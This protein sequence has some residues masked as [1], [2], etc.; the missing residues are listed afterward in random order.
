MSK[1]NGLKRITLIGAMMVAMMAALP[2]GAQQYVFLYKDGNTY[3]FMQRTGTGTTS[4]GN[5]TTFNA[6]TCVWTGN[7]T[8]SSTYINGGY[9]LQRV[10]GNT[11]NL[12]AANDAST[13][14]ITTYGRTYYDA[15]TD[16]YIYYNNGWALT[17][18][19][20]PGTGAAYTVLYTY[21]TQEASLSTPVITGNDILTSATTYNYSVSATSVPAHSQFSGYNSTT[22]VTYY[23]Y[24][25]AMSTQS[26]SEN[27]TSGTWSLSDNAA[28]YATVNS[29]NGRITVSSLPE[30]DITIT[31]TCSVTSNGSTKTVT[32]EITIQGTKPSA[33]TITISGSSAT[34]TTDAP[35]T[36][37][38]RYTTNGND[39]TATTGT[40]YN[41]AIDLSSST[42]SPVTIK[43]VTV[44]NGNASDVTEQTV[45]LTLPAPTITANAD[46][47]TA[48]IS[49]SV[50][51][52][53]IYYTT[54]GSTPTTSSSQ[55]TGALSGL[56]LMTTVQAI[57]VKDGW[58]ASPVATELLT[59]SSNV[60]DGVVTLFDYEDHTW[61]YYSG[62]D[63][64]V[65]GG[66]Y[67]TN[68]L[69]KLY[70]PNPRNVKITYNGV[71]GITGSTTA[72]K[73]SVNSGETQ[74]Q[75]VYYKTLEE[76]STSGEY[77]YQVIS[78]PFSVR[79][80]TGTGNSK[81]YYGFAGWK[82]VSG[83]EYI[84]NHNNNDV[85]ALDEEIV[86]NNLP[87]P[88]V[89]CTSAEIV[90]QTTWTQ[91]NVRTGNNI[92]TMLGNF[93]GGT[94]ETNFAVLTGNYTTAWTGNKNATITSVMPDGSADNRGAYTRLNVT[95][96][97]G[98]TI[99]YEYI[100]IN[101]SS[102]TLSMGT[103]TKTLYIG[104]GVSNTTANGVV[105][106]TI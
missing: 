50:A 22:A 27:V 41:G 20:N 91:A 100:N 43:A 86:F 95:V 60:T 25:G 2:A 84:K 106:A 92:A 11:L 58:N 12:V 35:G 23:Y 93:S 54:D 18:S 3:N 98:Y 71:N 33:P 81:V 88:S 44:R 31:L 48:T 7:G 68:Y 62:V 5:T 34:I 49:S 21:T 51:G 53:T 78:N 56:A 72:V 96:N 29:G 104:R 46:A 101:N 1:S 63:N 17:N 39:P 105:C 102:S 69:G 32:K 99:K 40:V 67:N 89:N 38:I 90:F 9:G 64:S 103:G 75:F 28:G 66:N 45:T 52:A 26:P 6:A 77:P 30:N 19:N 85:L 13:F 97:D 87:Y 47:G 42:T 10:S 37:T 14:Q 74:N 57:A 83:G 79:P 4:F 8:N 55:Y 65:D 82:I 24:N 94:Y 80:S 73:V 36:T 70:S 15:G 59:I 61:T 16:R 76:G